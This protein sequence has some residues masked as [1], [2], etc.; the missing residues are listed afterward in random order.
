MVSTSNKS[1]VAVLEFGLP[2]NTAKGDLLLDLEVVKPFNFLSKYSGRIYCTITP[3][4]K[5]K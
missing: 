2:F 3:N 5:M 1:S 4:P